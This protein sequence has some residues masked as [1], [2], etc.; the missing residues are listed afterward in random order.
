MIQTP[1]GIGKPR[2][3]PAKGLDP[4]GWEG[5]GKSPQAV[6][7]V[8]VRKCRYRPDLRFGRGRFFDTTLAFAGVA[9]LTGA[10]RFA[11]VACLV[12]G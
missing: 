4:E 1:T 11:G 12:G 5:G 9:F 7:R 6:G 2:R 10:G 3:R 8:A